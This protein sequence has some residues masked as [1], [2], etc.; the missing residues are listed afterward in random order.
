MPMITSRQLK[1]PHLP[2]V[3]EYYLLH[4]GRSI[5][6]K[7]LTLVRTTAELCTDVAQSRLYYV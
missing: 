3:L 6:Q 1:Q 5:H 7:I 4:N 2:L